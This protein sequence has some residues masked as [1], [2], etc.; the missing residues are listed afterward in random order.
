MLA[1]LK[2]LKKYFNKHSIT[3][4]ALKGSNNYA[5]FHLLSITLIIGHVT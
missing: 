4:H 1:T 2:W 5:Q 3:K